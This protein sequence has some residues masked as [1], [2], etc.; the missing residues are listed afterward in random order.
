MI[1]F[2]DFKRP[3]PIYFVSLFTYGAV[4][5]TCA[6]GFLGDR[7]GTRY[8]IN[9]QVFVPNYYDQVDTFFP[10]SSLFG[11][12]SVAYIILIVSRSAALSYFAVYLAVWQ[13]KFHFVLS[14]R[15]HLKIL[16]L[17]QS[18]LRFVWHILIPLRICFTHF[19]SQFCC[20]ARKQRRRFL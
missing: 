5:S 20:L 15:T 13:V 17:A 14:S 10:R 2:E 7:I 6:I 19:Y 8:Y 12:G 1:S 16:V 18:I 3:R 4:L 9:L 11:V